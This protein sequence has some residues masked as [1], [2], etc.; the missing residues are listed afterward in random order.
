MWDID[1]RDTG[2]ASGAG[3]VCNVVCNARPGSI[4]LLHTKPVTAAALPAILDGL[5]RKGLKPVTLPQL[6]RAAGHR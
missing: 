5:E 2:G 3:L 6:F 4:I 1:S